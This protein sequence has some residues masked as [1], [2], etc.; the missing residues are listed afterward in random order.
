MDLTLEQAKVFDCVARLGTLQR[1]AIELNKGHSA[2]VYSLKSLEEQTAI[3]LFD[4]T[5]YRNKLTVEGEIV[6]KYC[7]ELLRTRRELEDVCASMKD[8]WEPSLKI[9][10]DGIVN[11]DFL[12]DALFRLG[13]MRASTEVRVLSAYL[14]EVETLFSAERADMMVTILPLQRLQ[15]PSLK[16]KP[17]QMRLVAH[18]EHP[19]GRQNLAKKGK[20]R[21]PHSELN[22]HTFVKIRTDAGALGLGT[23][24]MRFD[25][26][27]Y[28]NDFMTKRTAILKRL[29]FGWLP[30]YLSD[31][32]LKSGELQ[33]LK[34]DIA[35]THLVHPHLYYRPEETIGKAARE[36]LKF[37]QFSSSSENGTAQF[38]SRRNRAG[39]PIRRA[40]LKPKRPR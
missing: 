17:I 40:P 23:E 36:L 16:L 31:I 29:G 35:N 32:E 2:V 19:L 33:L 8:G 12:G 5:G 7:R 3:V 9:I 4:R 34:T 18:R 6:L 37:F 15:I 26:Y 11:F 1:A 39:E 28:V 10:Y 25:S 20:A 30:D 38:A 22:R 27:F 24:Q 21:L 13:E 14:S